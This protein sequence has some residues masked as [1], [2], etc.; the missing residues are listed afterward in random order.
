MARLGDYIEQIRGV[1]YKPEDVCDQNDSDAVAILRANNIQD[2]GLNFDDLIYVKNKKV[3][4]NQYIKKGDIVVC[5]SSGSKNLVGKASIAREDLDVSFGAFCKVIRAKS[6]LPEYLG[7]YF[8]SPVYRK[9]ISDLAGGA[10]INNI[11]NEHI[12]DIEINIPDICEQKVI[13]EKINKV[14]SLIL[15]RKKQLS[16]FDELV[17]SRFVEMFGDA[18]TNS[19][20]WDTDSVVNVCD[21]IYGGGT[22]SKSHPEY[23]EN[24]NIPWISSKDMKTDI[25]F[26]SQIRINQLGV[27]NSTA[28][29]VPVNSVIMVIRS[30]ILKHTLPV[31]INAVPITINQDLK[32]FIPSKRIVS[33]FLMYQFKMLESDILSGVRAVTA[34]NIEFNSLKERKIIVPPIDLQNQFATFVEQI[35]KLKIEAKKSLEKLETLKK[36]LM[37]KYFG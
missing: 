1:S 37:Q 36:A 5:A 10:N 2:D 32:V 26:D 11:R 19:M 22:P 16:K 24:G 9:L 23:Y 14:L 7:C 20:G 27:D 3:S 6:I 13:S 33:L 17:K 4:V 30:G 15:C 21:D 8:Q 34:D 29:M 35:N 18:I 12:D 28:K 31:A 25:L